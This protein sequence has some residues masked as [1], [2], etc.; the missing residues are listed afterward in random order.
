MLEGSPSRI[1]SVEKKS[2]SEEAD[3]GF[4]NR[5]MQNRVRNKWR[6]IIKIRG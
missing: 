4:V 5:A 3:D 6:S 2:E 1:E